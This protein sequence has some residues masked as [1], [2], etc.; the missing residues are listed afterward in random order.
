MVL[1]WVKDQ[2]PTPVPGHGPFRTSDMGNIQIGNAHNTIKTF[3]FQAPSFFWSENVV[4]L[5]PLIT[6][7][8]ELLQVHEISWS[9]A[10]KGSESPTQQ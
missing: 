1:F 8:P 4:Q 2:G 5:L 3:W 6:F 10:D 7:F 9:N